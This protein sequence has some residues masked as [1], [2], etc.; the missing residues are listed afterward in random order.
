MDRGE[1]DKNSGDVPARLRTIVCHECD[2][3][4]HAEAVPRG[5]S[6]HCQR[7]DAALLR[8]VAHGLD[9]PVALALTA[10]VSFLLGNIFPVMTLEFQAQ[11][12]DATMLA[13]IW[14]LHAQG[15]TVVGL[16]VLVTAVLAPA[17]LT[18]LLL[19]LLLPLRFGFRAPGFAPLFRVLMAVSSWAM[20]EVLMLGVV[21]S[22]VKL[23]H[24]ATASAGIGLWAYGA[25][26]LLLTLLSS[27]LQ[28][29]VIWSHHERAMRNRHAQETA[30]GGV[31]QVTP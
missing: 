15:E 20:V 23:G 22:L 12:M 16:L 18:G 27:S 19:W 5:G 1:R 7:C 9:R 8:W 25:T 28:G 11:R 13:S 29:D 10:V 21:V 2:L 24:M 14:Q 17:L 30:D 6:L 3:L 31:A 26:M 4:Q